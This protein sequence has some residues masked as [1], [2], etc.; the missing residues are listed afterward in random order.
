MKPVLVTGCSIFGQSAFS[1]SKQKLRC[2]QICEF[3]S[4]ILFC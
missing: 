3:Q 4:D 2:Q 1:I